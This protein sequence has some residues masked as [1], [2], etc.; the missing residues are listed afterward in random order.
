MLVQPL[1]A[2]VRWVVA[3]WPEMLASMEGRRGMFCPMCR[4]K[5]RAML[6]SPQ[7]FAAWAEREGEYWNWH[8]DNAYFPEIARFL[9]ASLASLALV[10]VDWACVQ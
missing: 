1:Q 7:V 6:N 9:G 10:L 4:Q 8:G 2:T 3:M 5:R